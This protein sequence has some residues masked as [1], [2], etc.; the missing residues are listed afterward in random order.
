MTELESLRGIVADLQSKLDRFQSPTIEGT[1]TPIR[2]QFVVPFW[3]GV[4]A[5]GLTL[6][7]GV[8]SDWDSLFDDPTNAGRR[9][10]HLVTATGSFELADT[11]APNQR[12]FR[13]I[14]DSDVPGEVDC[15]ISGSR[16]DDGG[17]DY[18]QV[19]MNG[20]ISEYLLDAGAGTGYANFT[21]QVSAGRNYLSIVYPV[22]PDVSTFVGILWDG[23]S[24]RWVDPR[25]TPNYRY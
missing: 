23:Q 13:I 5:T 7:A 9:R 18:V 25:T 15:Q 21:L 10:F 11:G 12:C 2:E 16:T 19:K 14:F 22:F 3:D 6:T 17:V 8:G 24:S 1:L 4:Y 20:V